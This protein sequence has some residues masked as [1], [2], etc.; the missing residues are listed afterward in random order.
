MAFGVGVAAE[1]RG[2]L[3]EEAVGDAVGGD[4]AAPAVIGRPANGASRS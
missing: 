3:A 2:K 4:G 1:Q